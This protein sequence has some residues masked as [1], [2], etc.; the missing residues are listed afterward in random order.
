MKTY[1]FDGNLLVVE[2]VGALKDDAK[3]TLANLFGY[4]IV[5]AID[6]GR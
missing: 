3:R 1:K 2:E 4:S 6:V 5:D